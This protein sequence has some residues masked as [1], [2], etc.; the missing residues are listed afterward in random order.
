[1]R[2]SLFL[3]F[4]Q[5]FYLGDT[6]FTDKAGFPVDYGFDL[7]QLRVSAGIGVQWLSP[8]GLFRLSYGF[9]LRYQSGSWRDFGDDRE[10]FN[11]SI[12]GAF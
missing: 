8:L 12:G 6:Q 4:G 9:P 5:A 10:P 3:D 1:M 2:A 7:K 11:F